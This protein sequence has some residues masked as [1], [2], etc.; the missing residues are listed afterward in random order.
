QAAIDFGLREIRRFSP[1]HVLYL[2]PDPDE[3]FRQLTQAIWRLFPETPPYAGRHTEIVPHLSIAWMQMASEL[4]EI[5]K[6]FRMA[7]SAQLPITA[8]ATALTLFDN[9][10]GRWEP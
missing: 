6:D 10:T 4:R 3:P 2:A 8:R 7:A 1:D 9:V 5:E